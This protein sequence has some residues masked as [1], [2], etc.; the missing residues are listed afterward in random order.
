MAAEVI[1]KLFAT[2]PQESSPISSAVLTRRCAEA[3]VAQ[4]Q[5]RDPSARKV[6]VAIKTFGA[7]DRVEPTS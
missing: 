4:G 7:A 6:A 1:S 5:G 3:E 2:D